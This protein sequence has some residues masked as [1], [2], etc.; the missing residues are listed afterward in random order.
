LLAFGNSGGDKDMANYVLNKN[1]Y[2]SLAF[3]VCCDDTER[4]RGNIQ[5]ANE[6][7][8]NCEKYGWVPISMKNDWKTIYG[9]N[10]QKK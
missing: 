3:M 2:P 6:M 4:E 8:Q 1:K 5:K 7:K 9:E 10:V